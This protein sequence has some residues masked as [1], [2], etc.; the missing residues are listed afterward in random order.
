M[1]GIT[2]RHQELD[3]NPHTQ[4]EQTFTQWLTTERGRAPRTAVEYIADVRQFRTHLDAMTVPALEWTDVKARDI[5]GFLVTLKDASPHRVGRVVSS[6]RTWFTY[7]TAVERITPTNPA[8]EINKPKLPQRLPKAI[9]AR[10]VAAMLEAALMHSR[11]NEKLRNWALIAF[12]YGTGLRIDEALSMSMEAGKSIIQRDGEPVAVRVIGK[13]NKERIV[14]LTPTASRALIQWLKHR[15]RHGSVQNHAVWVNIGGRFDGKTISKRMAH[16]I[17]T[18][19]SLEAGLG[20]RSPHKL[21]HSFGTA[22]VASGATLEEAS[23][24]MGHASVSTT[25]IYVEVSTQRLEA[26]VMRLP[27]VLDMD[28]NGAG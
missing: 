10:G 12:L 2:H 24:V 7:L 23:K 14:P 28:A 8:L 19:A 4:L 1:T 9:E 13:G 17:T 22:F 20:K 5:R 6:L 26:S 25:Q 16:H 15:K 27:D 21:R 11:G 3:M 18:R